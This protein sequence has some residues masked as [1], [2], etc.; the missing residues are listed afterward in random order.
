MGDE[1][2]GTSLYRDTVRRGGL[3]IPNKK[4]SLVP[5][6]NVS[7]TGYCLQDPVVFSL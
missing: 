5:V 4:A 2:G 3:L 6:S 7:D 1:R